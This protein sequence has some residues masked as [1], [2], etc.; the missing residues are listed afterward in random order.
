M[1]KLDCKVERV[2]NLTIGL[3]LL[4]IGLGFALIGITILPVVGLIIAIPIL[5]LAGIFLA[6]PRSKACAMLTEKARSAV[7]K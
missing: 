3:I 1:D 7:A 2:S 5:L 4:M 6:A